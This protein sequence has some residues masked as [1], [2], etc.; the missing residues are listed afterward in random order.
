MKKVL[1]LMM[2]LV[3]L[4]SCASALAEIPTYVNLDSACPAVKEGT[5]NVTI[6]ILTTRNSTATNDIEDV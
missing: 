2:T 6:S 4:A 5:E 1:A 3:L